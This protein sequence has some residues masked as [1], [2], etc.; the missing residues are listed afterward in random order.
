MVSKIAHFGSKNHTFSLLFGN[1]IREPLFSKIFVVFR[2]LRPLIL[3]AWPMFF[4]DF[5][6]FAISLRGSKKHPKIGPK[7]KNIVTKT[8]P[9]TI[10]F[11]HAFFYRF[12]RGLGRVLGGFW[13]GFGSSLASLG[14]L[15]SLF[16][17]G[18][19][20]KRAQEG[21][22]GGQEVSWARFRRVLEGVWEGFGRPKLLKNRD[23]WYFFGYAFRDLNF[24]RILFDF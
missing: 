14:A 8:L 16:C 15:L 18:F 7:L 19:V 2:R 5:H 21:P 23:F 1:M 22:R 24:R 9:K 10:S 13:E 4:K 11:S 12:W 6:V 20:A 3:L 17:Q